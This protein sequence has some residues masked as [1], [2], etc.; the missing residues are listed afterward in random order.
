M[1]VN[2]ASEEQI[3]DREVEYWECIKASDLV[4]FEA[5]W[6]EAGVGWPNGQSQP[7][8]KDGIVAVTAAT[9]DAL[10]LD[11]REVELNRLSIHVVGDIGITYIEVHARAITKAGAPIEIRERST[12]TWL[13]ADGVWKIVAGMSAPLIDDDE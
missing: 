9:L 6:H 10:Q 7:Q 5:L 11:S 12:H 4:G 1:S 13:K 3:W 2:H 8:Q